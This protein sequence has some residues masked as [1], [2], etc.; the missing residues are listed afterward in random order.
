MR[1]LAFVDLRYAPT[2]D[3]RV[4]KGGEQLHAQLTQVLLSKSLRL[5]EQRGERASLKL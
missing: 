1:Q 4:F 5:N 3:G 2:G